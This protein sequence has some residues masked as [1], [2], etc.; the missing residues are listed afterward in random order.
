MST[1]ETKPITVLLVED[2]QVTRMGLHSLL[3][4]F[5]PVKVVGEA[6]TVA[7]AVRLTENLR[8][9]V[10]LLDIR[11]RDGSGFDACRQIQKLELETKVLFL[12]SYADDEVLFEALACGADGFIL[13]EINGTGLLNAIENVAAGRSVLDPAVTRRVLAR[14]NDADK[15]SSAGDRMNRLSP[16]ELRIIAL[17]ADGNTNKEIALVLGLSDK[18]VKNYLS[19]AMDK[20]NTSR[21]AHA[22]ALYVQHGRKT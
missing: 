17:V 20:L 15:T 1:I 14:L 21:R 9:D 8:P 11:L 12:T 4:S 16:Q 18:T 5:A 6:D 10:T 2:H 13:K 22:A 19:N 3:D 7:E